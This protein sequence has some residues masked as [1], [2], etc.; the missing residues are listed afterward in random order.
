MEGNEILKE[1]KKIVDEKE[2]QKYISKI[3]FDSNN[4]TRNKLVYVADNIFIVNWIKRNYIEKIL[5]I[6]K[7]NNNEIP[8]IE[9]TT[10]TKHFINENIKQKNKYMIANNRTLINSEY[11]FENF[12][13]GECNKFAYEAAREVAQQ[14]A[15]WNPLLI[16]GNTGLG[17]THLLSAICNKVYKEKPNA[18]IIFI[19]AE[20]MF[21]EYRYKVTKKNMEEF[22]ERFRKCDYLVIDDIQFLA[23][24]DLFQEEFFNTFNDIIK[25]KGQIIMSSDKAPNLIEKLEKR[26]KSRFNGGMMSKIESP[27]L[28]TK[29]DII[30]QKCDI[31]GIKLDMESI[32]LLATSLQDNIREIEGMIVNLH[33]HMSIFNTPIT[34][35][36]IKNALKDREE[37]TSI[38]SFDEIVKLVA[39]EYNIKPSEIKTKT[40]GKKTIAKARKIVAYIT[41][42]ETNMTLPHIA[43]ELNLK[44]HSA[45]SKQIKSLSQEFEKNQTLKNEV[46]NMISKLKQRIK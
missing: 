28:N 27:E 6:I 35:E 37:E 2:Y 13:T 18:I 8:N 17:K 31:N 39:L 43:S 14:K 24:T 40:R 36:T 15:K 12:I 42:E 23:K 10:K 32:S 25:N 33:G 22:R 4:S 3:E 20:T 7:K 29:I 5:K 19:T 9:I 44:D 30:K 45:V 1:L 26:L 41:R 11:S 34:I 21:N 16:Y 46:K 38:I